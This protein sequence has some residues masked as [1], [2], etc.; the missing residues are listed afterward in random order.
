MMNGR[1]NFLKSA[2]LL[3]VLPAIATEAL[4]QAPLET[5][6][7][8]F[9]IMT[10]NIR[11]DLKEDE[12]KG[13]GWKQR[14]ELCLAVIKRYKPDLVSFQ[15]VFY[16]QAVDIKKEFK[17]YYFLGYDGPEMDETKHT[18]G[19]VAKNP[20]LIKKSKFDLLGA[21]TYWLSETPLIGG[22]LSW[23]TARARHANYF[24]L[25][26]L[27]TGKEFRLVNTHLDHKSQPAR[28]KQ[29][30]LILA[31]VNQYSAS[32]P[33]IFTGDLNMGTSNEVVKTIV[34]SNFVDAYAAL[35]NNHEPGA[36]AHSFLGEKK[37]GGHRIDYIFTKGDVKALNCNL[38][39]DSKDGLYPSDHYFMY[40]DIVI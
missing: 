6:T 21:G 13:L 10:C 28:Q 17:D 7:G 9:R 22:S 18:Y 40:A 20:V 36:T 16:Q 2:A 32:F 25:K 15:E 8:K 33:Q 12:A 27:S 29:V 3:S 24:R 4:A 30:D 39:K 23:G 38:I 26:D 14:K 35:N 34:A 1:R 19:G 31:D 11:V 37:K 5:K